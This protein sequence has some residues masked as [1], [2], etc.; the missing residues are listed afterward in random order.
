MLW[1][2]AWLRKQSER[3]RLRELNWENILEWDYKRL[4]SEDVYITHVLIWRCFLV[5]TDGYKWVD[6][7]LGAGGG[8]GRA[9]PGL[10]ITSTRRRHL[11]APHHASICAWAGRP[12]WTNSTTG[13][14]FY[15]PR[16]Q[17]I[18]KTRCGATDTDYISIPPVLNVFLL[19]GQ[20]NGYR[21]AQQ[22]PSWAWPTS[23]CWRTSG[24]C[25]APNV[26]KAGPPGW[27]Q[28]PF[29]YKLWRWR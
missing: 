25:E 24:K 5:C 13:H 28:L 22:C 29:W 9:N 8:Q 18:S 23:F 27:C 17:F 7:A 26:W 6:S 11:W 19:R 1:P 4:S 12:C 10:F 16:G 3:S 2:T 14:A 21:W 20:N 15:R